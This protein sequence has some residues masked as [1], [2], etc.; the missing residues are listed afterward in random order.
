MFIVSEVYY[1]SLLDADHL[2]KKKIKENI[3]VLKISEEIF[4]HQHQLI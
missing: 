4:W 2:D 3:S 1:E